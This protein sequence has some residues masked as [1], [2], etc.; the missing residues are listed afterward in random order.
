MSSIAATVADNDVESN[1]VAPEPTAAN[2]STINN[3]GNPTRN[4]SPP[5]LQQIPE[6]SP[7][8]DNEL[9]DDPNLSQF[10][11]FHQSYNVSDT[12]QIPKYN[13]ELLSQAFEYVHSLYIEEIN[14]IMKNFDLLDIKR[15]IWSESAYRMD[16]LRSNKKFNKTESWINNQDT[17]LNI[18]KNDLSASV[19][20]IKL[21][22][23][24]LNNEKS[25]SV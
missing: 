18:I 15:S 9:A 16:L 12:D 7:E 22:L 25:S 6:I 3:N 13:W 1:P 11:Q 2:N 17:Y 21:T 4:C 23:E 5:L 24:K 19:N 8:F 14:Q 10:I 20:S